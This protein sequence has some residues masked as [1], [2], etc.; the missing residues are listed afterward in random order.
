MSGDWFL[1]R[2]LKP[3]VF[4]LCLAPFLHLL[5]DTFSPLLSPRFAGG[6]GINPLENVTDRTGNWTLRF[7]LV[8]L[9]MRP[10]R[11]VTGRGE[12]IRFR[13]MTGLFAFFYA[14]LHFSIFVGIDNYFDFDELAEDI[15]ERRFVTLG[16]TAWLTML[17][18][19]ITST[20]GWIRRLGGPRW[21]WLHRLVYVSVTCGVVH[22]LWARKLIEASPVAYTS[23][24]VI[25][26]GYRVA[27][28]L[29]PDLIARRASR[30][31]RGA[32]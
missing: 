28:W 14:T 22:F 13:R 24:A 7:L 4:L 30:P 15:A 26:L 16:F 3:A 18:L 19:A 8:S 31:G 6:L 25:L 32:G 5:W 20:R 21:Q 1:R 23:A 17:P 27:V 10:L 2:L 12:F 11:Q 29:R 9:A